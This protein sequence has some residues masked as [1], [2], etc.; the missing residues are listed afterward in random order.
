LSGEDYDGDLAQRYG[1]MIAVK[2]VTRRSH[3][4]ESAYF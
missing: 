4:N 1:W 2:I 3:R